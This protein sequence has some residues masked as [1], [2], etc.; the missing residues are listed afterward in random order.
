MNMPARCPEHAPRTRP[1]I[2]S[3]TTALRGVDLIIRPYSRR[4]RRGDGVSVPLTLRVDIG[5][6]AAA[7]TIFPGVW[8]RLVRHTRIY[9]AP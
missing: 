3:V 2:P 1:G 5:M 7:V 9:G 4:P 6:C 8:D